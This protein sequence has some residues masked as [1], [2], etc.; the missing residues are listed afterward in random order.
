MKLVPTPSLVHSR[1]SLLNPLSLLNTSR[2][3]R[4]FIFLFSLLGL[5]SLAWGE[6]YETVIVSTEDTAR[7]T[8]TEAK[9]YLKSNT[10]LSGKSLILQEGEIAYVFDSGA[11]TRPNSSSDFN[12]GIKNAHVSAIFINKESL[13]SNNSI[14]NW[15]PNT[16]TWLEGS[17]TIGNLSSSKAI[18][19]PAT[20]KVFLKPWSSRIAK[21]KS[22]GAFDANQIIGESWWEGTVHSTNG[23]F[24]Y[25]PSDW[26]FK[27]SEGYVTFRVLG[28]Q[29][30]PS[31]KF[32]TVIPENASTNVR[33]IL[34][35]STDLINWTTAAPGVFPPS[36]AKRF[37]RVRSEEE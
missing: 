5:G 3:F 6:R 8:N 31:K 17:S 36:T 10:C 33:V 26:D 14:S 13:E 24:S 25:Y 20:V 12:T 2:L 19:G 30:A 4:N 15:N 21:N 34:E 16:T 22:G 35:Q 7:M 28:A 1:N 27:A 23:Y 11:Q 29:E 32:A 9:N 37:F 18:I